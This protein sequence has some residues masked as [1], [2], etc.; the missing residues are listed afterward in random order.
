MKSAY[1]NQLP[2][3]LLQPYVVRYWEFN[4]TDE[5]QALLSGTRLVVPEIS[6]GLIINLESSSWIL[7]TPD[8]GADLAEEVRY[9]LCSEEY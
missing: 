5:M 9:T 4:N 2:G 1:Q 8:M 7:H 3:P 6:V